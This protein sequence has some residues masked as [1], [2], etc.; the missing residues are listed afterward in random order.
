MFA[1]WKRIVGPKYI[2]NVCIAPRDSK[3]VQGACHTCLWTPNP[4][5]VKAWMALE[6]M[7]FVE[8]KGV[9]LVCSGEGWQATRYLGP[10][11]GGHGTA[12][13]AIDAAMDEFKESVA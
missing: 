7:Q 2:C 12:G 10:D 3:Y 1:W 9:N 6:R 11:I 13:N 8:A 5:L 4:G